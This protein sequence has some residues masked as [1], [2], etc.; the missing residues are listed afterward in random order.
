MTV[1][2]TYN[3]QLRS[4]NWDNWATTLLWG[5]NSTIPGG[6]VLNSHLA[7]RTAR[8]VRHNFAWTRIENVDRTNPLLLGENPPPPGLRNDFWRG[9]RRTHSVTI[10]NGI[11]SRTFRRLSA[12]STHC[13]RRRRSSI[14]VYGSHP[15]GVMLILRFRAIPSAHGHI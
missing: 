10:T 1:S 6:E 7:E 5:R 12:D 11:S 4:D 3:R 2:V 15:M 13:T 14:P 9:F 8:F